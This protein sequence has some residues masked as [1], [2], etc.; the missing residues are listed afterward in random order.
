MSRLEIEEKIESLV[1][2]GV[3]L[4]QELENPQYVLELLLQ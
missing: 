1:D 3:E 4:E 2:I